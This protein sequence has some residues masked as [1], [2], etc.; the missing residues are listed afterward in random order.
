MRTDNLDLPFAVT[1]LGHVSGK[2]AIVLPGGPCRG[3]EYLGDLAG[4]ADSHALVVL[5]PRGTPRS[6]GLSRGWWSDA[7]D[8]IALADAIGTDIVD[9]VAHSAGTRLA[10]ATAAR[11]PG[12]VRSMALVT[13]P[14][15]WLT[16]TP[17]D[18]ESIAAQRTE[19]AV[20][21]ALAAMEH[22]DPTT[23]SA[24]Q[25]S[26]FRQ[27]PASYAHWT[28]IEQSHSAVGEVS[29]AA[30]IAWFNDVP[31]NAPDRI[32]TM[33]SPPT[34]V[35]GGDQDL[36]TGVQPVRDYAAVL[37]A[38]LSVIADCGHYPWVE[39]PEVFHRVLHTWLATGH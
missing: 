25:E 14:A 39:Q 9:L 2:P 35:I 13:P 16:G 1:A 33:H 34:L 32:R 27:A 24:F 12:R 37:D 19:P 30:A 5:H 28:E 17:T 21:T 11:F 6:E 22:D 26:F 31:T 20:A 36:L 15:S 4:L 29:R 8:V 18:A 3:P 7:D 23:E 10:L 38:E